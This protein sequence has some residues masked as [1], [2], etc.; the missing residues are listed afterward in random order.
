VSVDGGIDVGDVPLLILIL[1]EL[2]DF[3]SQSCRIFFSMILNSLDMK[4]IGLV[5]LNIFIDFRFGIFAE[6]IIIVD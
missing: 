3:I 2:F 4:N 1:N 6:G 5:F